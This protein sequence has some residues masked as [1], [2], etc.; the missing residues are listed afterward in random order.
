MATMDEVAED[1]A[2]ADRAEPECL[3]VEEEVLVSRV[4]EAY[5]ALRPVNCPSCRACM[6][7]PQ[8]IDVPRIFEIYNDAFMYGDIALGRSIYRNEGHDAGQCTKCGSCEG[9][10]ARQ[11]PIQHWLEKA[12]QLLGCSE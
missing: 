5:W 4:R 11:L 2:L 6:P 8:G 7:C 1:V 3:T 12:H 9:R 10:C